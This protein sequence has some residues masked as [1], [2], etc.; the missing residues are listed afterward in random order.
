MKARNEARKMVA[1]VVEN[2]GPEYF[3]CLACSPN[4]PLDQ[5]YL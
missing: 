4:A 2:A 3:E 5:A 1:I